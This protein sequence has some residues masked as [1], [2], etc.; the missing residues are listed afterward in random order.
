MNQAKD[1]SFRQV[2]GIEAKPDPIKRILLTR[3]PEYLNLGYL[4]RRSSVELS[5]PVTDSLFFYPLVGLIYRMNLLTTEE[6][7]ENTNKSIFYARS[8]DGERTFSVT[9][10]TADQRPDSIYTLSVEEEDPNTATVDMLDLPAVHQRALNVL[11]GYVD[12]VCSYTTLP[13]P[14]QSI[15]VTAP[16]KATKQENQWN[17]EDKIK[18]EFY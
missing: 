10:L 9:R 8:P 5:D 17:V 12:P 15:R 18:I 14:G 4:K 6:I 3:A 1:L 13:E 11:Q 16:G 2:F 7:R